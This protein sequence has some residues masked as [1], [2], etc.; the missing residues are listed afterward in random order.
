TPPGGV[1][2]ALPGAP[3]SPV[4]L[5]DAAV[6]DGGFLLLFSNGNDPP[7]VVK[8]DGAGKVLAPFAPTKAPSIVG[9][10]AALASSGATALAVRPRKNGPTRGTIQGARITA[11]GAWLDATP[12]AVTSVAEPLGQLGVAWNGTSFVI[13]WGDDTGM[14]KLKMRRWGADG[15]PVD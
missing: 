1:T 4:A 10:C 14:T 9:C 2:L 3:P 6:V 15:A 8:V 5:Q 12:F 7:Q 13:Q 11:A